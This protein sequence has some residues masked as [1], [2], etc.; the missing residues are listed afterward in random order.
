MRVLTFEVVG[1]PQPQGS[2]TAWVPTDRAGDPFRRGPTP[3]NPRG[4]IIVNVTTD[5]KDLKAWRQRVAG[6]ALDE[7]LDAYPPA[8]DGRPRW[9]RD[10]LGFTLEAI[11]FLASP[12]ARWG[13]GRNASQLKDSAAALPLTKPDVDK[14]LRAFLDA[15]TGVVWKDD[16]QVT[17]AISRKRYAVP[18]GPGED[19]VRAAVAVWVNEQQYGTDLDERDRTR[20]VEGPVGQAS[21]L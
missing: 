16:S 14:L 4:A 1:E 15:L 12:K 8:P 2:V 19:G 3:R 21:L 18:S 20:W 6:A 10:D 7:L 11:S 9:P 17:D 13:T 5:N